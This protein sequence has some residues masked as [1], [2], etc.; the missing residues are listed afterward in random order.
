[1]NGG[2]IMGEDRYRYRAGMF[3]GMALSEEFLGEYYSNVSTQT[4]TENT[5]G[6]QVF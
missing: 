2:M 4:V 6:G 1:M 5:K 3:D